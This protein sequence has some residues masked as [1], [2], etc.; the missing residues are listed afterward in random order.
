MPRIS[1]LFLFYLQLFTRGSILTS[2]RLAEEGSLLLRGR[3]NEEGP[4]S[5]HERG[6]PFVNSR[7]YTAGWEGRQNH[8]NCGFLQFSPLL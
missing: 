4:V 7:W 3:V 5:K 6:T 8:I 1:G 2:L